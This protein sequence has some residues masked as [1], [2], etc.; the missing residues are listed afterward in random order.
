ML[1]TPGCPPGPLPGLPVPVPARRAPPRRCRSCW[2]WRRSGR[3]PAAPASRP[4]Q[5]QSPRPGTV[6]KT[7]TGWH[8]ASRPP[9][10]PAAMLCWPRDTLSPRHPVRDTGSSCHPNPGMSHPHATLSPPHPIAGRS[11]PRATLSPCLSSSSQPIP[12]PCV[13]VPPTFMPTHSPLPPCPWDIRTWCHSVPGWTCPCHTLSLWCLVPCCPV[14][15]ILVPSRPGVT[16]PCATPARGHSGPLHS[17]A[18]PSL[19]SLCHLHIALS[20]RPSLCHP[21]LVSPC[22]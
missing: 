4:C 13:P 7:T 12:V 20:Q 10:W 19:R 2:R 15:A 5:G 18:V 14:P 11:H 16:H 22:P 17:F 8:R 6:P 1:P 9:P 21:I 3:N